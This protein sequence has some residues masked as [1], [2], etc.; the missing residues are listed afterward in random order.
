MLGGKIHRA[1]VTQANLNYVGSIALDPD[2]TEAAQIVEGE[3]VHVLDITNGAR[4]VT[5][6]IEGSPA[7][8]VVGMNGAAAH[9]VMPGDL[10]IVMSYVVLDDQEIVRHTPHVVHVDASN[11]IV[12][13]GS[14]PAQ[15]AV[16]VLVYAVRLLTDDDESA[17]IPF[18][19]LMLVLVST[20]W[21]H[22]WLIQRSMRIRVNMRPPSVPRPRERRWLQGWL[23]SARASALR[24]VCLTVVVFVGALLCGLLAGAIAD[25]SDQLIA[26]TTVQAGELT[27]WP[28][29]AQC[30]TVTNRVVAVGV[31]GE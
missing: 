11:R 19:S 1:T 28:A 14:N 8:G 10:I 5:Y 6:A 25:E 27:L 29:R 17:G 20:A 13:L 31:S 30:V 12:A 9:L 22:I 2:L 26:G 3:Q 18:A 23:R 4:L 15:P 7:S 16:A 21:L 24:R